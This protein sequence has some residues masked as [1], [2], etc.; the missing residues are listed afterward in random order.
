MI[1][2]IKQETYLF[3]SLFLPI[4]LY[5]HNYMILVCL[6]KYHCLHMVHFHIR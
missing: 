4:R 5:S 6:Y 2:K 3:Y 1:E